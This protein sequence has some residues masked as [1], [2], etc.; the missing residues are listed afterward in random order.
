MRQNNKYLNRV[1]KA[2]WHNRIKK[3]SKKLYKHIKTM[4][5]RKYKDEYKRLKSAIKRA[6]STSI[7]EVHTPESYVK[8]MSKTDFIMTGFP[9]PIAT[10]FLDFFNKFIEKVPARLRRSI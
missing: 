10:A 7:M 8:E 1:E 9:F 3:T 4:E 2:L 6:H 5:S